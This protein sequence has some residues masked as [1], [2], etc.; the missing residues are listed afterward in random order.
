M[1][2][3]G[4]LDALFYGVPSL[5]PLSHD[6]FPLSLICVSFFFVT[7]SC[8]RTLVRWQVHCNVTPTSTSTRNHENMKRVVGVFAEGVPAG[9]SD[10]TSV[11]RVDC[12]K[13]V[14]PFPC[15]AETILLHAPSLFGRRKAR[16][17]LIGVNGMRSAGGGGAP[18]SLG[19]TDLT[20]K[21]EI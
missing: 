21:N 11:G 6:Y 1:V 15:F 2:P 9:P 14:V 5:S 18:T 7:S 20:Q 3:M 13:A 19:G 17:M 16:T 12:G 4:F 8:V 10:P